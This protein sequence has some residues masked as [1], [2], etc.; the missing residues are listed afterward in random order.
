MSVS[1]STLLW[2]SGLVLLASWPLLAGQFYAGGDVP[3]V[4]LPL[5]NFFHTEM[6]AGRLPAWQPNAA[7]GFPVIASAQLG[8][9]YPPLL[10]TRLLPIAIYL[11]VILVLHL[12]GAA[13]GMYLFARGE[14]ISHHGSLLAATSFTASAFVWQHMTHLN[15]ILNLVWLPW[16]FIFLRRLAQKSPVRANQALAA[17]TMAAPFLAGHLHLSVLMV[18]MSLAYFLSATRFSLWIIAKRIVPTLLLVGALAAAQILPTIELAQQSTRATGIDFDL[19]RANQHSWPLYHLPTTIFPRFFG[20]DDTYW[21]KRLEVEYGIFIGTIPLILAIWGLRR[22]WYSHR[23]FVLAGLGALLLALGDMSPFR[24]IGLEPTFW[25]FTAPARWLLL[26]TFSA[27]LLSGAGLDALSL[28][29]RRRAFLIAAIGLTALVIVWNAIIWRLPSDVSSTL[30]SLLNERQLLGERPLSYYEAKTTSLISSVRQS[31]LSLTSWATWLPLVS[32]ALACFTI[33]KRQ[34]TAIIIGLASAELILIASTSNP[35]LSWPT[36]TAPPDTI[37]QLPAHVRTG[38]S[39]L[40]S[41]A[42]VGDT[43]LWLSNPDS[44]PDDAERALRRRLLVPLTNT[45]FSIAGPQWPASLDLDTQFRALKSLEKDEGIYLSSV[46]AA[47]EL[48]I[49]AIIIDPAVD[50]QFDKPTNKKTLDNILL[51]ELNPQ[52]RAYLTSP[53]GEIPL[54]YQPIAPTYLQW[55]IDTPAPAQLV[56]RDTFYPSWRATVDGQSVRIAPYREIFRQLKI[57]AGTHTVTMTYRPVALYWGLTISLIAAVITLILLLD[58]PYRHSSQ[59][60]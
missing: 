1:R 42:K 57:P 44:R 22:A 39:R 24:L 33:H 35:T 10:L 31:S 18:I 56:V 20:T 16:Q 19:E 50:H 5:E 46:A 38:A 6:L 54:P 7:W 14:K 15:I 28:G 51:Y 49:G 17:V 11:P 60:R 45:R 41:I 37:S 59:Y 25:Y 9:F 4:F 47:E 27:A 36:L 32:V 52:P 21:G 2:L 55:T 43:G 40:F 3:D 34:A 53:E 13:L 8:F 58:K 12:F 29:A 30:T 23:F 48:N 26:Y